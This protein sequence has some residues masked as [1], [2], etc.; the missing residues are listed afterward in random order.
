[1]LKL[2]NINVSIGLVNILYDISFEVESG[3]CVA[4][5]G[6]NGAGKSTTLRTISGLIKQKSGDISMDG[7][8]MND[9]GAGDRVK[10]GI[11]QVPEGGR[12]FPY[13]TI[14]E[15]LKMGASGKA[16]SW[17]SR[18]D[19]MERVFSMFPILKERRNLPARSLSGGERQMLAIGRGLMA[20]PALLMIDEPSIGLAPKILLEIY[21]IMKLLHKEGV[22]ILLSEQNVQKAL[23]LASRAYVMENGRIVM[24]GPS[25]ELMCSDHIKAAYLGV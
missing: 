22:T 2:T 5:L 23:G 18:K 17:R 4:L 21:A 15:N 13:L 6:S 25:E 19:T 10:A 8:S 11:I 7:K 14:E 3:E 24:Q 9:I 12:V 16:D 20:K 1:M